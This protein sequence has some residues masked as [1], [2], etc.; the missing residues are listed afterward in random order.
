MLI[1]PYLAQ[2]GTVLHT[3]QMASECEIRS[4]FN[5][6]EG[7]ELWYVFKVCETETKSRQTFCKNPRQQCRVNGHYVAEW[8]SWK[9]QIEWRVV[10]YECA[11]NKELYCYFLWDNGMVPTTDIS[12][13]DG[14]LID[15]RLWS[16]RFRDLNSCECYWWEKWK[17]E[18]MW[19]NHKHFKNWKGVFQEK[20]RIFETKFHFRKLRDLLRD[21]RST[22]RDSA[23]EERTSNSRKARGTYVTELP[24]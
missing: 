5:R 2:S 21:W 6:T 11:Q 3:L 24:W 15:R 9:R 22:L 16:N 10:C 8:R 1:I 4:V 20:L 23:E 14:L 17:T 13:F 12:E 18:L 19:T 7:T